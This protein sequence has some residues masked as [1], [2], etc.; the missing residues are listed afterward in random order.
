MSDLTKALDEYNR[1]RKL[2]EP[3]ERITDLHAIAYGPLYIT[4]TNQDDEY[5]VP[6]AFLRAL[7]KF[8]EAK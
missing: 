3:I 5:D 8:L 6:V 4:F 1:L 2:A 7:V